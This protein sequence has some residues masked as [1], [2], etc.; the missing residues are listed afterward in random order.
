MILDMTGGETIWEVNANDFDD[1]EEVNT[2]LLIQIQDVHMSGK[3]YKNAIIMWEL[4]PNSP[5]VFSPI[6]FGGLEEVLGIRLPT[7]AETNNWEV[8]DVTIWGHRVGLLF[9]GDISLGTG[10]LGS[11][12][13][14]VSV[15]HKPSP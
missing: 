12:T 8:D 3:T 2:V 10:K 1:C 14:L 9:L 6:D 15:S 7:A 11:F 5:H 13:Y 4:Q